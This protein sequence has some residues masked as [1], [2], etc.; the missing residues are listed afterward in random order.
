MTNR[1]KCTRSGEQPWPAANWRTTK[2]ISARV[3]LWIG[4]SLVYE[5]VVTSYNEA[6][7]IAAQL[8]TFYA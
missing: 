7:A 6:S 2:R 8:K 4:S 1:R 3:L 5:Q